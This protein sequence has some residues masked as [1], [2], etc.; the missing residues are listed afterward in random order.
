MKSILSILF[1][2]ST[3]ILLSQVNSFP[4]VE[5]F[6]QSFIT[7]SDTSFIPNWQGNNV[8]ESNRIFAGSNPRTGQQSLNIIPTSSFNGTIEISLNLTGINNPKVSFYAFSKKNGSPSSNRPT[9]LSFSTSIDSGITYTNTLTIGDETTFPNNDSTSYRLYTFDLPN[10]ASGKENV[11]L[12]LAAARGS[13][14]G[15]A[16]ELVIDDFSI[17][18]Q[19]LPV[20][21]IAA[22]ALSSDSLQL[23]FNQP[24]TKSSAET[25]SNYFVAD[26]VKINSAILIEPNLVQLVTS[27]LK[28]GAYQIS[29]TDIEGT[30]GSRAPAT[31][32]ANFTFVEILRI[33]AVKVLDEQTIEL[34][35]NLALD[36]ASAEIPTNYLINP[37]ITTPQLATLDQKE[38]SKVILTL[39]DTLKEETYE[40]IAN[41]VSDESTLALAQNL[42]ISFDYLPLKVS[43]I[44][45]VSPSEIQLTFNQKVEVSSASVMNN[46]AFNFDIQPILLTLEDSLVK[47]KLNRPLVNNTYTLRMNNITNLNG[48]ATAKNLVAE[49]KYETATFPNEILI[50]EIFAD[51]SGDHEPEPIILP[52]DTR[53]EY[54]ELFN[55]TLNAIDIGNFQLS[56]GSISNFVLMPNSY[57]ILT[58][59]NNISKFS[60]FGDVAGVSSWNSL[61]NSG[62]PLTLIDNL[63]NVVDSLTYDASWYQNT[64]KSDGGWSIEKIN[65]N[66][67]CASPDNWTS[68]TSVEGGTPGKVNSVFDPS[69]DTTLPEVSKF[70][71]V[72]DT[73]LQI[74]FNETMDASTLSIENF[75]LTNGLSATNVSL[76]NSSG[77]RIQVDLN[78]IPTAGLAHSISL[79]NLKDCA[80]NTLPTTKLDFH[81]GAIPQLND[82]IITEIMATPTPSQGLP[83]S[84]YLE[85]YNTSDKILSIGGIVLADASKSTVLDEIDLWP[86]QHLILVP[87]NAVLDFA[88]I[89]EVLGVSSWV[90]LNKTEDKLSLYNR[91]GEKI[92]SIQYSDT[93][94]KSSIKAGGGFSLEMI[95]TSYPCLEETNWTASESLNGGSPGKTN[96]V[97]GRN[98][99]LL[100]P[101]LVQAVAIDAATILLTFNEKLNTSSIQV[102]DFTSSL[103]LS[104]IAIIIGNDERTVQLTTQEDLVENTVYRITANSIADCSGNLIAANSNSADLIIA[105]EAEPSDI[106]INEVLFNPR[107]NGVRFVEIY[108]NSTKYVNLKDWKISGLTNARVLSEDNLFIAPEIFYTITNDGNTLTEQYPNALPNT[109]IEVTSMPSLPSDEGKVSLISQNEITVDSFAYHEDYHSPLLASIEGVSLERIRYS[110]SSNDENNWFS[111]SS[112]EYSATP[113]YENSQSRS[114]ETLATDVTIEPLVF[115]PQSSQGPNFVTIN[116]SFLTAGNIL[117][118]RVINAEGKVIKELGQNI[119]AGKEGF[120]IWDGTTNQLAKARIGYYM[121]LIE[122]IS[123]DG[124]IRYTQN[125]VVVGTQF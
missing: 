121:V 57:V 108:N 31:L 41:N 28:N 120:F 44:S 65:P 40:I 34:V 42:K 76:T 8:T 19:V 58:A 4:Y 125:K 103:G 124:S 80:G 52:N 15:S 29:V 119:V 101:Q 61:S 88:Q 85:L 1:V 49:L 113:G 21:L 99:D 25:L 67:S 71:L 73:T 89:G 69:L 106:I 72:N 7:G 122:I 53:D 12:R 11:L 45:A 36:K 26:S 46:Y 18:A 68:S 84:E 112:T 22:E 35:F 87:N 82:I 13:G 38:K 109:F 94:F 118:T 116:Y 50:N 93:W 115:D 3:N 9:L 114:N 39:T 102:D 111:A 16:A 6:E 75:I 14:S 98:P 86:N 104:F 60:G 20:A 2:L 43:D 47:L 64:D 17:E 117:N 55:N 32:V 81:I 123:P 74:I 23:R 97:N 33:L 56:G 95:D 105:A 83:E 62:E 90:S 110:G 48:N 54:I 77:R 100:G 59:N 70:S 51:P 107:T 37:E 5:S 79:S 66:P 78:E 92:Y 63:G 27:P 24:L 10:E 30:D 91:G 96:S